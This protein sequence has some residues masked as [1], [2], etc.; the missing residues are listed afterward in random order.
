MLSSYS[1]T[2]IRIVVVHFSS[3]QAAKRHTK[4]IS[5][6]YEVYIHMSNISSDTVFTPKWPYCLQYTRN[7]EVTVF[8]LK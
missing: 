6:T 4:A 5:T 7:M 8:I 3:L 1:G 2:V